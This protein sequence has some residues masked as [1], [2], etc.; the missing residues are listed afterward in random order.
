M[1]ATAFICQLAGIVALLVL[2]YRLNQRLRRLERKESRRDIELRRVSDL[3]ERN[4]LF[5]ALDRAWGEIKSGAKP[6]PRNNSGAGEADPIRTKVASSPPQAITNTVSAN[7]VPARNLSVRAPGSANEAA[8]R[9]RRLAAAQ[10]SINPTVSPHVTPPPLPGTAPPARVAPSSPTAPIAVTPP[11]KPQTPQPSPTV[12]PGEI[13]DPLSKPPPTAKPKAAEGT[14]PSPTVPAVPEGDGTKAKPVKV[15]TEA[16]IAAVRPLVAEP[17]DPQKDAT[18]TN[19]VTSMA[20][21]RHSNRDAERR[22]L[23]VQSRRQGAV[24]S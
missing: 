4:S 8:K 23:K 1:L 9:N 14:K 17:T 20:G 19:R 2:T 13:A 3:L 12:A 24:R 15:E 7:A 5:K 11:I 22:D 18:L 6:E 21:P 10:H 16:D